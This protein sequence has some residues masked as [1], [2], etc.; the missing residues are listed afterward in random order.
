MSNE[1]ILIVGS[2]P[3]DEE[4]TRAEIAL[5]KALPLVKE[6]TE[7]QDWSKHWAPSDSVSLSPLVAEAEYHVTSVPA[8]LPENSGSVLRVVP[9]VT[10][11]IDSQLDAAIDKILADPELEA[12]LGEVAEGAA[13]DAITAAVAEAELAPVSRAEFDAFKAR[14][15]KAFKHAGFKF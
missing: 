3:T 9:E 14:V 12:L 15:E 5:E 10:G 11:D 2:R 7:T 8:T 1:E 6:I 13:E 4:I